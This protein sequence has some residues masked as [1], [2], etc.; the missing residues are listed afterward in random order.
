MK[1]YYVWKKVC[2][3]RLFVVKA[4][5]SVV[6]LALFMQATQQ[7]GRHFTKKVK[8]ALFPIANMCNSC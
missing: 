1:L 8:S 5:E 7:R 6:D 2:D 3:Q 4:T